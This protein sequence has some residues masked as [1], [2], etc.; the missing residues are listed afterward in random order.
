MK[1][2]EPQEA[3]NFFMY[4]MS[5]IMPEALSTLLTRPK[6]LNELIRARGANDVEHCACGASMIITKPAE[7]DELIRSCGAYDVH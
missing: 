4:M 6:E 5:T 2:A 7:L 1:P 3:L